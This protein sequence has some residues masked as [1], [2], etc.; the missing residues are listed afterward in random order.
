MRQV[1][2]GRIRPGVTRPSLSVQAIQLTV[3]SDV[4]KRCHLRAREGQHRTGLT[5]FGV[6]YPDPAA[7]RREFDALSLFG[8]EAALDPSGTVEVWF[9]HVRPSLLRLVVVLRR[10]PDEV[11]RLSRSQRG[12]GHATPLVTIGF[13]HVLVVEV[14]G[15]L[16]RL[17]VHNVQW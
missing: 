8:A 9:C 16:E 1:T 7:Y 14:C 13:H 2:P 5:Q 12:G 15:V 10:L 17:D 4:Q 11:H 6:A 3:L